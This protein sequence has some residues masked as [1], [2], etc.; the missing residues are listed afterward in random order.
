MVL[1]KLPSRKIAPR[2]PPSHNSNVNRKP[3]DKNKIILFSKTK[4]KRL[5]VH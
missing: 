4:P 5:K 3:K 1:G 2:P